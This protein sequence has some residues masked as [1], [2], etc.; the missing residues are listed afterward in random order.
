MKANSFSDRNG[1]KGKVGS[2]VIHW[3][4]NNVEN[5][6]V[7]ESIVREGRNGTRIK[8]QGESGYWNAKSY[9]V[10]E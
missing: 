7:V 2:K 9:V 4:A 6:K 10:V 3:T 1:N 8:F 5:V